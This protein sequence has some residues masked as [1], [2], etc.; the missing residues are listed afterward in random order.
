MKMLIKMKYPIQ[1]NKCTV[2]IT[3]SKFY[4]PSFENSVDPDQLASNQDPQDKFILIYLHFQS[5]YLINLQIFAT[6]HSLMNNTNLIDSCQAHL[7]VQHTLNI[8]FIRQ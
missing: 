4:I 6:I 5:K 3:F 7:P 1:P 2:Y 8:E